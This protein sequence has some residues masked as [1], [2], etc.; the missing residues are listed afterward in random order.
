VD[1]GAPWA[2]HVFPSDPRL[3]VT[4]Q[5]AFAGAGGARSGAGVRFGIGAGNDSFVLYR[6]L[7]SAD[8]RLHNGFEAILELG[9]HAEVGRSGGPGAV[10]EGAVDAHQA[11]LGWHRD[12]WSLRLGRQE[13]PFGSSRIVS[14]R[15]GPNIRL[16]F[17]GARVTW[18]RAANRLDLIALRPVRNRPGAFDDVSE[19]KQ[20]LWGAYATLAPQ[21]AGPARLDVYWLG[22]ERRDARFAIGAGDEYRQSL[23][24]RFFGRLDG[25]DWNWEALVQ[26]GR[27][28]GSTV[29]RQRIRAWTMA[30]DSGFTLAGRSWQPRLGLKADIASGDANLAD[31]RLQTFNGLFPNASYFSQASLLA[32]ANL[33]DLQPTLSVRPR[34]NLEIT[35]GWDLVWKQRRADAVYTTPTPLRVLP[36]SI[37]SSRRVG[38]Q[39]KLETRLRLGSGIELRLDLVHFNAGPAVREAGG[40]DVDYIAST[41]G[42]SW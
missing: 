37:G 36:G 25:W 34:P 27:F 18:A 10:D 38:N 7:A 8:L 31:D 13:A 32:P 24:A 1:S 21:A 35:A 9:A 6:G 39:V 30:T 22:Y 12:D 14:V 2:A 42:W 26:R 40:G 20:A 17:D 41:L 11:W 23:G 29:G 19:R 4:R 16:A 5:P 28:D 15:D 33:I 3:R